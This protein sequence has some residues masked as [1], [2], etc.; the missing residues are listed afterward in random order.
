MTGSG[1]RMTQRE[2]KQMAERDL[3]FISPDRLGSRF[4]TS[5]EQ[6]SSACGV[7]GR[8][9]VT[10]ARWSAVTA[11]LMR[12]DTSLLTHPVPVVHVSIGL[13]REEA[14]AQTGLPHP[15]GKPQ[16]VAIMRLSL[17]SRQEARR[18]ARDTYRDW[19]RARS[20]CLSADTITRTH[21]YTLAC[22]KRANENSRT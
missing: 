13:V 2:V 7:H 15:E 1:K 3:R 14:W 20:P 12:G 9:A 21:Q 16:S 4:A 19:K 22:M 5:L 6:L 17:Q 8:A 18:V 11:W 10:R